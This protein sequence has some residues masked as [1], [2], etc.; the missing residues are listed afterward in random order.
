MII[1][2]KKSHIYYDNLQ[3]I[4][5]ILNLHLHNLVLLSNLSTLYLLILI[6]TLNLYNYTNP[7]LLYPLTL[8]LSPNFDPNPIH[9]ETT[10]SGIW[11]DIRY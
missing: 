9:D 7:T 1:S 8:P 11:H 10:F 2:K 3:Q 4:H 6:L 5:I